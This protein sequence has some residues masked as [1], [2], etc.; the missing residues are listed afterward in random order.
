[1]KI[2]VNNIPL[3]Q[4]SEVREVHPHNLDQSQPISPFCRTLHP[5][6]HLVFALLIVAIAP[7]RGVLHQ[8]AKRVY[9]QSLSLQKL[10]GK[11]K[12]I[13][14]LAPNNVHLNNFKIYHHLDI[15]R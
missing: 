1:M 5:G 3:H 4:H 8:P 7:A 2:S 12:T 11:R 15:Y 14:K 9:H 10:R 13:K 6:D